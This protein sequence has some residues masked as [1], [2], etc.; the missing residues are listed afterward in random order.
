MP[1]HAGKTHAELGSNMPVKSIISTKKVSIVKDVAI[2]HLDRVFMR[3]SCFNYPG[4]RQMESQ[5]ST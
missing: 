5:A 4:L 2:S 3:F 1:L